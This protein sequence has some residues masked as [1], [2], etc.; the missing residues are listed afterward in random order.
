[1]TKYKLYKLHGVLYIIPTDKYENVDDVA[2]SYFSDYCRGLISDNEY[3]MLLEEAIFDN[4]GKVFDVWC[5]KY[6][7]VLEENE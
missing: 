7:V 1:M 4:G 3:G 5:D 6:Y 2:E